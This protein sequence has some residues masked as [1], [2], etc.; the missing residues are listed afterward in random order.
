MFS[1]SDQVDLEEGPPS[2]IGATLTLRS[3]GSCLVSSTGA[4]RVLRPSSCFLSCVLPPPSSRPAWSQYR[5]DHNRT[6]AYGRRRSADIFSC[7]LVPQS[8]KSTPS[9]ELKDNTTYAPSDSARDEEQSTNESYKPCLYAAGTLL[10]TLSDSERSS[11][12]RSGSSSEARGDPP[13]Q[14]PTPRSTQTE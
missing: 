12:S 13:S 4:M 10:R 3:T 7:V 11:R 5:T 14:S 2:R 6:L 8:G 9:A 1:W